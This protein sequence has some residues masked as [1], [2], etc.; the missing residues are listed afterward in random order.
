MKRCMMTEKGGKWKR[1]GGLH[2]RS[3][4][5]GF[6]AGK[7]QT[8]V[9]TAWGEKKVMGEESKNQLYVFA[10]S[11]CL[12]TS[13]YYVSTYMSFLGFFGVYP[14]FPQSHA[15]LGLKYKSSLYT[16]IMMLCEIDIV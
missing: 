14:G 5:V 13:F 11:N 9:S 4:E 10:S 6:S 15:M 8:A 7:S 12:G 1:R 16:N 2:S 3:T